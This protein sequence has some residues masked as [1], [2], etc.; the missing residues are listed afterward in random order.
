MTERPKRAAKRFSVQL[1]VIV[2]ATNGGVHESNAHTRDICVGGIFFYA[3]GSFHEGDEIQVLL[4]LPSELK[5]E[6]NPWVLCHAKVV[7]VEAG[8]SG[9]TGVAAA[10]TKYEVVS[11]A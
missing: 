6:G 4:P 5:G 8:E 7:R 9:T 3:E 2:K 10:V 1:P 11:A